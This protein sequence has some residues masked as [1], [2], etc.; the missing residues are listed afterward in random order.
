MLGCV[1]VF[2]DTFA[3]LCK[4]NSISMNKACIEIGISRTS[5]AKWK[6][7]SVPNGTTLNKIAEYFNVS[8]DYLVGNEKK[9]APNVDGNELSEN[10][11]EML[12][13]FRNLPESQQ[14]AVLEILKRG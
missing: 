14:N 12:K 7:G 13:R 8:V 11:I 9:P 10:E 4:K 5:T 3:E 1:F 2:I 6:N